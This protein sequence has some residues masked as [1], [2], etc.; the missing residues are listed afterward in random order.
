MRLSGGKAQV[1]NGFYMNM[2]SKFT[3]KDTSIHYYEARC[4]VGPTQ[5]FLI[6]PSSWTLNLS[7]G[8]QVE[9]PAEPP[10]KVVLAFHVVRVEE[11]AIQLLAATEVTGSAHPLVSQPTEP[12]KMSWADFRGKLL[13]PT[14]PASAPEGSLRQMIYSKWSDLG[15]WPW[16]WD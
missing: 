1:I 9:W 15:T 16:D 10:G 3:A 11:I 14:D 13:G 6:I 5:V 2:R 4:L 8:L 12:R 7:H